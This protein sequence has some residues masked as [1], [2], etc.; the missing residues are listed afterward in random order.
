MSKKIRKFK[1]AKIKG[2]KIYPR[3]NIMAS[4]SLASKLMN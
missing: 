1:T 2:I 3:S 4:Y